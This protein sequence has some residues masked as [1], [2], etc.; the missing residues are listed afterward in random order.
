[1]HP[2]NY[3]H[4]A[5]LLDS[6]QHVLGYRLSWQKSEKGSAVPSG[7]N[8]SQL[9]TLMAENPEKAESGLYFVEAGNDP[10]PIDIS[11]GL[12]PENTVLMFNQSE[13]VNAASIVW[14]MSLNAQ[15]F[16]L[17]LCDVNFALLESNDGL[18]SLMTHVEASLDHPDMTK[19]VSVA[20]SAKPPLFVMLKSVPDWQALDA[21]A[22]R[23]LTAFF[24]NL[25]VSPR[26]SLQVTELG[27]Q[28]VVILQLMKM[29]HDNADIRELEKVL[30]R[31]ATLSYKLFRHIN[32]ASFGIEVE[33]ESLRHAVTMLGYL[34]L[35]RWL[36]MLLAMTNA[37][38]FSPALLQA[39]IIRG[40]FVELIGQ[41]ML[42]RSEAENL[43]VVGL[44]SLLDQL[45]CIPIQQ[46][47]RQISLP[48]A[49]V[50]ALLSR[51][52]VYGPL[53]ALAEACELENGRAS[54]FANALFLTP[55]QVN[56]AHWS[57]L[58]W[59]QNLKI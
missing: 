3:F 28:A 31:D 30:K 47:L 56:K 13:L 5:P 53:L 49:I 57:A 16:G 21:C 45:L 15:G 1:M 12:T 51:E 39:A 25:C 48:E 43:F 2:T 37:A 35:Y 34:P 17:A 6:T 7:R 20:R 52:G 59:A 41:G 18:L 42:S 22:A 11:R 46:I 24:G 29:V 55:A 9:L 54:D 4:R 44:F 26:K 27:P 50:Q 33:I 40:R 38:G 23:G 14:A 8:L 10:I 32:A 36:S 58:V 19:I